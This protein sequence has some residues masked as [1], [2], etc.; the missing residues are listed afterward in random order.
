[1][2]NI[3]FMLTTEQIRNKTKTVTRR[4][5]WKTLKPGTVLNACFKCMGLKKGEK[6]EKICQI[7]VTDVRRESL[8]KMCLDQTYGDQEASLE[9]FPD[10]T[11]IE[12]VAMFCTNMRVKPYAEVTRIEFEYIEG[13]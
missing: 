1:M 13:E 2:R 5:G 12:F 10:K 4:T 8:S 11:G 9:G 7:R 3:S 6:V